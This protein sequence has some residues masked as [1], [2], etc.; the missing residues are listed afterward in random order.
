[1]IIFHKENREQGLTIHNSEW[2]AVMLGVPQ[3]SILGPLLFNVLLAYL[4]FI[5]FSIFAF[6][7]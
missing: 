5:H 3:G 4:L 2:L 6:Y 1:M 7:T